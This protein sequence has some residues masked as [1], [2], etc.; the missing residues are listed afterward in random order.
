MTSARLLRCEGEADRRADH[1]Q[2]AALRLVAHFDQAAFGALLEVGVQPFEFR[3]V[4]LRFECGWNRRPQLVDQRAHVGTQLRAVA[5]GQLQRDRLVR[6]FEVVDVDPVVAVN[7][8][9]RH[10]GVDH[11]AHQA[12][13]AGRRAGP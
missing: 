9:V 3:S 11:V 8:V 6:P 13:L 5:R 10:M 7:A 12:A 4:F 2:T 1:H